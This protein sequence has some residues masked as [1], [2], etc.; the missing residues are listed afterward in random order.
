MCAHLPTR[1]TTSHATASPQELHICGDC[2]SRFVY[3]RAI[4][5]RGEDCWKLDLHCPEC[6]WADTGVFPENVIEE[7]EKELERGYA[8]LE[9]SLAHLTRDNMADYTDR[10]ASALA[11]DAIQPMDF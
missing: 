3:P 10:F 8:E 5:R 4:K 11:A 2:D 1:R 7:F 6:G 9:T